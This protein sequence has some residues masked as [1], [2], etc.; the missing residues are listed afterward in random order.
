MTLLIIGLVIFFGIHLSPG[1]FGL[2]PAL[3]DRLG[4]KSFTGLYIAGSVV[5]MLCLVAG[6]S[7][8]PFTHVYFPPVGGRAA[9]G[10]LMALACVFLAIFILPSNFRRLTRHPML[11]TIT[12]WSAAHLLANGDLSSILVFGAFGAYSL[13]S[14]WS[15]NARGARK[16]DQRF[17]PVRD[18]G[19]LL[20]AAGLFAMLAWAHPFVIGVP[21][22]P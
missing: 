9:A 4:E 17:S 1:I 18:I 11:W 16:S 15:L 8:A 6:K 22:L 5:G 12:F 13:V 7:M 19:T 21:A 14:M 20:L 2:R 3:T 10:A